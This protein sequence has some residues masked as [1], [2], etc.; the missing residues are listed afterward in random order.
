MRPVVF[1]R[2]ISIEMRKE[3]SFGVPNKSSGGVV[4]LAGRCKLRTLG[5][6]TTSSTCLPSCLLS[7][8]RRRFW[9]SLKCHKLCSQSR[10]LGCFKGVQ[11]DCWIV[12]KQVVC[13]VMRY[14]QSR[15]DLSGVAPNLPAEGCPRAKCAQQ[16]RDLP[17]WS[18]TPQHPPPPSTKR[19]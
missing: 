9:S 18:L 5:C 13:P 12:G 4:W 11:T 14:A 2:R 15:A 17:K 10:G 6:F 1:V 7:V 8:H 19:F 16:H 3:C